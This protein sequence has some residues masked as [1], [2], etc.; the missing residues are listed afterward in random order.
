MR[1]KAITI[2]AGI[3]LLG[4]LMLATGCS[5]LGPEVAPT[6]GLRPTADIPDTPES[7]E[8]LATLEKAY[9]I[10]GEAAHTFNLDQFPS[11]FMNDPRFLV[12]PD[13]LQ[14]IREWTNQ[15]QLESAGLLDYEMAYWS[16]RRDATGNAEA[17]RAKAKAENRPL[18]TEEQKSLVDEHG[19]IAPARPEGPI[20]S[21]PLRFESLEIHDDIATVVVNDGATTIRYTL[22]LVD[23]HWYV[24]GYFGLSVHP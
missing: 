18:T 11:V 2:T 16:W 3:F 6:P 1:N 22:V 14:A 17:I 9:A 24:A 5:V 15:P 10:Q 19:R 12:S 4:G 20:R 7:R 13:T 21:T 23:H 8:V